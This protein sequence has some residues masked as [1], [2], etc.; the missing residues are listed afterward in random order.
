M[1]LEDY[2]KLILMYLYV[3]M[4]LMVLSLY[5]SLAWTRTA[6][7][8]LSCK[9]HSGVG[10]SGSEVL[11]VIHKR[12]PEMRSNTRDF[13]MSRRVPNL[14]RLDCGICNT[15]KI[16]PSVKQNIYGIQNVTQTPSM[17]HA[18]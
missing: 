3:L 7:G 11:T 14:V 17:F 16:N 9:C 13:G 12:G 5:R 15:S 6:F 4:V 10:K 8:F 2:I 18:A 1:H